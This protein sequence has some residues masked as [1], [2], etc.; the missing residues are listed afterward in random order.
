MFCRNCG[1]ELDGTPEICLSCGA[2]PLNGTRFCNSCGAP[3]TPETEICMKCGARVSK[4][5][6]IGVS[7]KSRLVVTL[8]A[9]FLGYLGI[10]RFYIG[11]T[12]T[13]VTMLL[14]SIVGVATSWIAVGIP[15]L[16]AVEI[17][18]LIDFIMAVAGA[19]KD[20]EGNVIENWDS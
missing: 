8:L 14:L 9:F 10:H 20:T 13:A 15:M 7:E 18:A 11:K 19:M 12:G 3:T 4:G 16:V 5:K 2:K 6:K 17:W 1:K